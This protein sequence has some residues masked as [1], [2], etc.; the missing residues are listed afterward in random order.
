MPPARA[1]GTFPARIVRWQRI[2]GRH[3]LPWQG[4]RDAYR[5][6]LSEIMLQQTQVATV[7]PYYER[8]V[9]RFPTVATLAAAGLDEVLALWSGLG[10]YARGRNLHSAAR[11]VMEKFAGVFP[12][13]FDDLVGLPGI[14]RSTAAAIAAFASGERRAILDGNVRRVLARH[15]G[16][17]GDPASA[18]TLGALW[19][20][21]EAR[22]PRSGIEA[23]TQGM[24]DLGAGV[25]MVRKP[26]CL[27][28]PVS[29]DCVALREGRIDELPGKRMRKAAVH[30][31]ITMLVVLSR[32]EVL[33]QKRA[34][35]GIWGGLWS[36]PEVQPDADPAAALREGYGIEAASIEAM[37]PFE[38]AFT[39][40]TLEVSPWRIQARRAPAI[41]A[42]K[43]ATWLAL[44]DLAGCALPSP[45]RR[46]LARA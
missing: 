10:Y 14:G 43:G 9:A 34:P 27:L 29:A 8:F 22:L 36:L 37:E 26:A 30:R 45:V 35:T 28:C 21:A 44:D 31:R 11:Q 5:I 6:W 1:P 19:Q 18:A 12:T 13:R 40:F 20:E 23:Y 7:L 42:E 25:C 38:H 2:H 16:I 15:A 17:P 4:T 41:A 32:G 3:G 46:L 33:L 24:M 39:H